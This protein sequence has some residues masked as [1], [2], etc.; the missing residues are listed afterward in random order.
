MARLGDHEGATWAMQSIADS[1]PNI[2]DVWANLALLHIE[3]RDATKAQNDLAQLQRLQPDTP[4]TRAMEIMLLQRAGHAAQARKLLNGYLAENRVEYDLL[5]LGFSV[6]M[7]TKDWSLA[8]RSLQ[9]RIQHWPQ[10]AAIA[11]D[12]LRQGLATLPASQKA[13]FIQAMPPALRT[14]L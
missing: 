12:T 7:D 8:I 13:T 3:L 4:R 6:G 5:L 14:Q 1:R 10:D 11:F 2:P 9:L